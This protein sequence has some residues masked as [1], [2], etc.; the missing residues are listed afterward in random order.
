MLLKN[1]LA[2]YL[3]DFETQVGQI[4]NFCILGLIFISSG[5]FVAETFTLSEKIIFWL[6]QVDRII[7]IFFTF[8]YLVRI[9]TAENKNK[10]IFSLI[11]FIDLLAI[12]PL[13]IGWLDI[14]FFRLFRVFRVLRVIRF[15]EFEI[16]I[17]KIY[18]QDGVILTRIFLTLFTLIFISSGLIYQFE[19]QVNP[20]VF[21][22]FYDAFYFAIV[23]MTTVG[24][25]DLTPI[26][27]EGRLVTLLMILTGITI[28][29]WQLGELVKQ[30][31]K[32]SSKNSSKICNN[33]HLTSHDF[34]AIYCKIC[35]NKLNN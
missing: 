17:F 25:G 15:L 20:S 5:I 7:L 4:I 33:C 27:E 32:N 9:W 30:F 18:K 19:H 35:G 31:V 14:R 24:F 22:N 2:F 26:S 23:T 11:S 28:I 3:D 8:E 10:F 34:D 12:L 13:L 1:K 16:F 21:R 29:P 6:N